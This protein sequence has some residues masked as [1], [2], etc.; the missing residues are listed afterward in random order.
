MKLVVDMNLSPRWVSFLN[1]AGFEAVH[2]NDV[3]ACDAPDSVIM[4]Y[5]NA[6]R[7]VVLTHDLDFGSILAATQGTS[8]S[9]VQIRSDDVDLNLI[10][11]RVVAALRQMEQELSDGAL[12]TVD[13]KRV[14]L[15]LLPLNFRLG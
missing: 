7:S 4:A 3:G 5:A 11:H 15:T 1:Q 2:W 14:R 12:V 9:V 10:G 13:P 6:N 8:P